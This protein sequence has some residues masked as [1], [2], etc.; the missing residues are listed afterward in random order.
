[1]GTRE[2]LEYYSVVL[3]NL[4]RPTVFLVFLVHLIFCDQLGPP[5]ALSGPFDSGASMEEYVFTM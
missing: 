3:T 1:M 4:V 2:S 5:V